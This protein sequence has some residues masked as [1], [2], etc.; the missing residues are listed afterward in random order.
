MNVWCLLQICYIVLVIITKIKG[1]DI[2]AIL[3]QICLL[4]TCAVVELS[5]TREVK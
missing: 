4:I 1:D 5:K 3:Y 2:V